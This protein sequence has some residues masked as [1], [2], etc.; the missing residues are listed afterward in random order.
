M[1]CYVDV[2]RKEKNTFFPILTKRNTNSKYYLRRKGGFILSLP[3]GIVF[4][5][6]QSQSLVN[7]ARFSFSSGKS[8]MRLGC[9]ARAKLPKR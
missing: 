8:E 1:L 6:G 5:P 4:V 7:N 9:E 2:V 3:S